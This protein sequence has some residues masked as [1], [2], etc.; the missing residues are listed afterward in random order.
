MV[1]LERRTHFVMLST[2]RML[3]ASVVS[4]VAMCS[5]LVLHG[6][7]LSLRVACGMV[8]DRQVWA[9]HLVRELGSYGLRA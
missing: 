3:V 6:T 1:V 7:F 2:K 5:S 4:W 9:F 8:D